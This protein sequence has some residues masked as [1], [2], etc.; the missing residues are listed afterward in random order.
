VHYSFHQWTEDGTL[1]AVLDQ[2]RERRRGQQGRTARPTAAI[3]DRQTVK[4]A[5]AR[6]EVGWDGGK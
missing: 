2:L 5:D 3:I 6:T 1:A 4:T